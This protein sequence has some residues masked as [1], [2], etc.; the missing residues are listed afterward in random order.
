MTATEREL[1]RRIESFEVDA[2]GS[3]KPFIA[4]LIKETGWTQ[5]FAERVIL[6]YRRYAFIAATG[7]AV[8]PS[9]IVDQVWHLHLLYTRSYWDRFC[10]D[11]LGRPL[12]HEPATGIAG[13][14]AR[15]GNQYRDTLARYR[16]YFGEPPAD[17]WPPPDRPTA[18]VQY[19]KVDV[20][21]FILLPRTLAIGIAIM[22]GTLFLLAC[23][24]TVVR[25]S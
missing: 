8:S 1:W 10:R 19:R 6:E 21:R 20:S 7:G 24:W 15:L 12:H 22:C 11:T 25:L 18:L 23:V 3:A 4:R 2:P 14:S 17:I 13:E 16:A 5:H 9:D